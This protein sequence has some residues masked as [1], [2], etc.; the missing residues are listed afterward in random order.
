MKK[1]IFTFILASSL[2]SCSSDD[3]N[4]NNNNQLNVDGSNF[5]ITDAKA[6]DNFRFFSETHAE[7][8]FV[9]ASAPIT[10]EA[11]PGSYFAYETDNAKISLN[12]SI[13]ALGDVFQ[14]GV[15]QYNENLGFEEPNFNFFD[16]FEIYIDN[17][18]NGSYF[19]SG[20]NILFATSGTV[21]VSGTAPNYVLNFDVELSNGQNFEYTYNQGFDYVDNRAN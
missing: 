15:Y 11:D 16:A 13:A 5:T 9:L 7:Y 18:Q 19:D 17:N 10:I 1:L 12:L 20:D 3:D 8:N 6:V 14:N 2:L 21:T 4:S